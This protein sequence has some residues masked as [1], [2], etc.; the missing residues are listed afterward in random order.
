MTERHP[1]IPS[2][3]PGVRD[4]A[5]ARPL[6]ERNATPQMPMPRVVD[7]SVIGDEHLLTAYECAAGCT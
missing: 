6:A 2:D 4:S 1:A 5:N 3:Q 7:D